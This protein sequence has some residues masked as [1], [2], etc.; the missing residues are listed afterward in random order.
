MVVAAPRSEIGSVDS[1]PGWGTFTTVAG[2]ST[3]PPA[4]LPGFNRVA[5]VNRMRVDA[6]VDSLCNSV[7]MPVLRM[8]WELN[9]NGAR[10]EVVEMI[11]TDLGIPIVGQA[12]TVR[13]S[14][15]RFNHR[16]HV[17]HALLALWYGAMFFEQVPDTENFDLAK[18]GWRLRKLAPRMPSSIDTIH[19]ARDGGLAGITQAG[20]MNP[21]NINR[22]RRTNFAEVNTPQISVNALAAYVW[23]REGANW[24][25]RSML[26]PLYRDWVLKDRALRV[27]SIKNERFGIG[28]PT[29]TAPTGGDPTQYAKLAQ[30][31][32]A[33]EFGGVGLEAGASIGIEGIRGTL[34]DIMGSIR[35]YDESM[36]RSFM[37]MV[38]QLGQTQTGSRA[39][40]ETFAD[41]FQM[42]IEAV[43]NWYRDI[44]NEHVIEDLVD[45]NFGEEEAAPLLQW[46]F[47]IGEQTLAISELVNMVDSGLITMDRELETAI[48]QRTRLP[49][50]PEVDETDVVN[51]AT[52][53]FAQ[54]G[55]PA[56][57]ESG[58]I[59]R[60]EA[61]DLLGITGAAPT[62]AQVA[63]FLSAR[64][65]MTTE[66]AFTASKQVIG[67][68]PPFG[69]RQPNT[70]ELAAGTDFDELQQNWID[71]TQELVD[72]W[73]SQVQ[74]KQIKEI[75]EQVRKAVTAGDLVALSNLEATV[76]GVDLLTERLFEL[77]EDA[78][79]GAREE[80]LLQGVNI[81]TVSTKATTEPLLAQR[82]QATADLLSRGLSE[83]A[84]RIAS[85]Y[86][87]GLDPDDVAEA[88]Q[89]HLEGLSDAY[90]NDMLGGAMTQAQNTGRKAVFSERPCKIYASELLDGNTCAICSAIDGQE[91]ASLEEAEKEYPTG[92]HKGCLGGPRCRGTLVAVYEEG[93]EK[94][95]PAPK[96][97]PAPETEGYTD[98]EKKAALEEYYTNSFDLNQKLRAGEE[99][100]LVG[101][102][103]ALMQDETMKSGKTLLRVVDD[104]KFHKKVSDMKV[105]DT[106]TEQA[107]Q[108]RLPNDYTGTPRIGMGD[109]VATPKFREGDTAFAHID[110]ATGDWTPERRKLHDQ[111][112][113]DFLKDAVPQANP[114]LMFM[115][116]GGG[117]GKTTAI[118][119]GLIDLPPNGVII[120]ADDLK[121][122][123]PEF[124]GLQL[125]GD[126]SWAAAAHEESSYLAKRLREA[127]VERRVNI[128]M[129]ALGSDP[130]KVITQVAQARAAG[131][132]TR[133]SYV[134]IEPDEGVRRAQKRF[135]DAVA[136]GEPGRKISDEVVLH[137]H[138]GAN[139]AFEQVASIVD[140]AVLIDNSGAVPAM[141]ARVDGGKLNIEDKD[142]WDTLKKRG[143][144]K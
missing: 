86:G 35:Y 142:L 103:D 129:D 43:A 132:S 140:E 139:D 67:G 58:I 9:P 40:G 3:E 8:K 117:A 134:S 88:V 136:K 113:N 121:E 42:L 124:K 74:S 60:D 36:A 111:I 72:D 138:R 92:G 90:L 120:N 16:D 25:G 27:D 24:S 21:L 70:F 56:L 47:P 79:V 96:P 81:G 80:A 32:R 69:H 122:L 57:V 115:G 5:T 104:K 83:T 99:P 78:I 4:W 73:C 66:E 94:L 143:W 33:S 105:G 82:A 54:V 144:Q 50:L 64:K 28:I 63:A 91:F 45:W 110:P 48:R 20:W 26:R 2:D 87:V 101:P 119:S 6:Q 46:S 1:L 41:H 68:G 30:S 55:L 71:A 12:S 89:E 98:A 51:A 39:L 76:G 75:V 38:V 11:S 77:A 65:G 49:A 130:S 13:R 17:E 44:T 107:R 31:I 131:Y 133:A 29:A 126:P 141:I 118:K 112:V 22:G 137:A 14:R 84:S 127:G 128:T 23:R 135:A 123:V 106:F 93:D 19:T 59:S 109:G 34:P 114:Q 52:S 125:A 102:L 108:S 53:P 100:D 116:G 61:R 85:R 15:R 7:T 10:D 62:P 37:A 18:D 95:P 97:E